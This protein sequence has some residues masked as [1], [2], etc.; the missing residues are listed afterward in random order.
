MSKIKF[1]AKIENKYELQTRFYNFFCIFAQK[2]GI[3]Q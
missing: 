3:N 1:L 2:I